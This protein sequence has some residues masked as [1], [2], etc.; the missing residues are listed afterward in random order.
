MTV[1]GATMQWGLGS[2]STTLNSTARMLPLTRKM[3][4]VGT[5]VHP[6]VEDGDFLFYHL[7][8]A[9]KFIVA[10]VFLYLCAQAGKLP[11]STA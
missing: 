6:E 10:E 8:K 3:S 4:P 2:V 11:G 9:A 1:S 5:D 7:T